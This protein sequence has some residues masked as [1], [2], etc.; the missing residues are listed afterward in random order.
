ME[1]IKALQILKLHNEWRRDKEVPSKTNM[2][3]SVEIGA[4][5]DTVIESQSELL[6]QNR[7][8]KEALSKIVGIEVWISDAK[9]KKHFQNTVYDCLNSCNKGK[10]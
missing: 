7:E 1:I 4:A 10:E 3:S 2:Q 6:R 9:M 8:M 5:I